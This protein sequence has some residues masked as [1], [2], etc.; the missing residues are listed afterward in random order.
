MFNIMRYIND[1]DFQI[2]YINNEINIINYEKIN[3]MED[4]KISIS[5]KNGTVIILGENLRA[6][7]LLDD[8]IIIAGT[9]NNV[10]FRK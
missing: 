5:Y 4:S 9:F 10:E 7:K 6:K 3:Y 1:I 8:E 2:I